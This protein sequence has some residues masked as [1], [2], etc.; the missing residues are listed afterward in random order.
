MG[1]VQ[2]TVSRSWRHARFDGVAIGEDTIREDHTSMLDLAL[3]WTLS[4]SRALRVELNEAH[5]VSTVRLFDNL[6]HQLSVTLR[7]SY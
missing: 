6:Y 2:W 5:N 3:Q 4:P 1:D 7:T